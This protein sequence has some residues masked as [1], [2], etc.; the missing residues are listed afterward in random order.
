MAKKEI[1]TYSQQTF[2]NIKLALGF[3]SQREPQNEEVNNRVNSKNPY[4]T[5]LTFFPFLSWCVVASGRVFLRPTSV[6]SMR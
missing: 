6:P 4:L 5:T 3:G 2:E 1:V